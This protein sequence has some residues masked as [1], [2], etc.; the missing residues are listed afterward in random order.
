MGRQK[1]KKVKESSDNSR[2]I[3]HIVDEIQEW[4]TFL[5]DGQHLKRIRHKEREQ[6]LDCGVYIGELHIIPCRQEF[7]PACNQIA[8]VCKCESYSEDA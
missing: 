8:W 3:W 4:Q 1:H 6:C 2:G 5:I 7:C